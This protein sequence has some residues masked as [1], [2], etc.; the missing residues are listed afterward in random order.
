M[1]ISCSYF[2]LSGWVSSR[3]VFRS[4]FPLLSTF[5]WALLLVRVHLEKH[6]AAGFLHQEQKSP[7][8]YRGGTRRSDGDIST[9]HRRSFPHSVVVL[10]FPWKSLGFTRAP[11]LSPSLAV[12]CSSSALPVFPIPLWRGRLYLDKLYSTQS[13]FAVQE[14]AKPYSVK[15]YSAKP[16]AGIC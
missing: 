1:A 6:C 14:S 11:S 2:I 4:S 16:T 8:P 9:S 5:P 7:F 12:H 13:D 15:P 3:C 10:R